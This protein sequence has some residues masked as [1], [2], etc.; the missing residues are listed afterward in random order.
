MV[1]DHDEMNV[2]ENPSLFQTLNEPPDDG[3]D[4]GDGVGDFGIVGSNEVTLV[5]RVLE[6]E[7][8]KG[9]NLMS[10]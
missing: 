7:S 6:V 1:S 8:D 5:V 3:V 2:V 10:R 9:R 4:S